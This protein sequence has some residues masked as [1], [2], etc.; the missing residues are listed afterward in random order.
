MDPRNGR[1]HASAVLSL[2]AG[3]LFGVAVFVPLVVG[4]IGV[5]PSG[6]FEPDISFGVSLTALAG[7]G[8][9]FPQLAGVLLAFV[10]ALAAALSAPGKGRKGGVVLLVGSAAF[11][12]G[13]ATIV[14]SAVIRL[15]DYP[16]DGQP[17]PGSGFWCLVAGLV[18][19]IA[20][21]VAVL[22]PVAMD[23]RDRRWG[24]GATLALVAAALLALA[25]IV[26]LSQPVEP[27]ESNPFWDLGFSHVYQQLF[28]AALTLAAGLLA[29]TRRTRGMILLVAAVAF[30]A[31]ITVETVQTLVILDGLGIRLGVWCG[32]AGL[33]IALFAAIAISRRKP[34][35]IA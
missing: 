22:P 28:G 11:N 20:A 18:L 10:A 23:L 29:V 12:L 3:V 17:E 1:W 6:L 33:L 5:V 30:N 24:L 7:G 31:S 21:A 2:L 15:L 8:T 4:D 19:A 16:V 27:V 26:P 32:F 14:G 25:P 35:P 34:V 13:V 9:A